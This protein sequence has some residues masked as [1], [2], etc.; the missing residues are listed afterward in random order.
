MLAQCCSR[1]CKRRWLQSCTCSRCRPRLDTGFQRQL[2]GAPLSLGLFGTSPPSSCRRRAWAAGTAA[3]SRSSLASIQPSAAAT[4]RPP[5]QPARGWP[6]QGR[7]GPVPRR[8]CSPRCRPRPGP[9]AVQ[10]HQEKSAHQPPPLSRKAPPRP[11][12]PLQT[13]AALPGGSRQGSGWGRRRRPAQP[14]LVAGRSQG[15]L[16]SV[17]RPRQQRPSRLS[18][19][20]K[21]PRATTHGRQAQSQA[22][23]A[24]GQ[25]PLHPHASKRRQSS[26]AGR[27]RRRRRAGAATWLLEWAVRAQL[28][29][30][31]IVNQQQH[32]AEGSLM[33]TTAAAVAVEWLSLPPPQPTSLS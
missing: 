22:H 17:H 8:G 1:R 25:A 20:G 19:L 27:Q 4:T 28:H 13:P 21:P 30:R 9:L 18:G 16:R 5:Q 12:R 2:P 15:C 31:S 23:P 6:T 7:L 3:S 29:L 33:P 26:Q 14:R 11:L 10:A 32:Q 24:A